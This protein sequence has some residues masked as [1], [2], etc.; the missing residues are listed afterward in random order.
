MSR[1]RLRVVAL[2]H[3]RRQHRRA[4]ARLL[5]SRCHWSD[6]SAISGLTTTTSGPGPHRPAPAAGS[7]A[8][9]RRPSASR[10]GC[11]CPDSAACTASRWPGL[12]ASRPNR[13]SSSSGVGDGRRLR[14][15]A[16]AP[17]YPPPRPGSRLQCA[18]RDRARTPAGRAALIDVLTR[19][20]LPHHARA[21]RRH[22]RDRAPAVPLA[23]APLRACAG[24]LGSSSLSTVRRISFISSSA[25]DAPMQRRDAPAERDPRERLRRALKEALGP[26]LRRVAR[27][28]AGCG[29]SGRSTAPPA[30]PAGRRCA[31][32]LQLL[33]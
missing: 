14:S 23:A 12:N 27:T 28:R 30:C 26:E 29:W 16:C 13:A 5:V 18:R 19:S 8:T 11:P 9:C 1:Q 17:R 31:A 20:S 2:L 6:I 4:H 32:H 10:R 22:E 33:A 15:S 7:T 21:R 24:R 3:A 25:N